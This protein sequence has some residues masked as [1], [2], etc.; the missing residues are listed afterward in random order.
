MGLCA[1]QDQAPCRTVRDVEDIV[2]QSTPD[3]LETV[4]VLK[5]D[6]ELQNLAMGLAVADIKA[7]ASVLG[8][9]DAGGAPAELVP[10]IIYRIRALRDTQQHVDD[11]T[12]ELR[13]RAAQ[14]GNVTKDFGNGVSGLLVGKK[15]PWKPPVVETLTRAERK[16]FDRDHRS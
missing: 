9:A 16:R 8:I 10:K 7:I 5:S 1:C 6:L 2:D 15:L 13:V 4:T 3:P 12:A 11:A 14:L